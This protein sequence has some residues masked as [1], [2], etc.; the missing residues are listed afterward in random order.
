MHDEA[1]HVLKF[2]K[3]SLNLYGMLAYQ[4]TINI[5]WYKKINVIME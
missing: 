1:M 3:Q 2:R 4:I 5:Y